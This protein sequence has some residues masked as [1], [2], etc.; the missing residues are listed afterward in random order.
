M[1]W[2]DSGVV[3]DQPANWLSRI[4]RP[5]ASIVIREVPLMPFAKIFDSI[6]GQRLE[7]ESWRWRMWRKPFDL[8]NTSALIELRI[9]N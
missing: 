1:V 8:V 2:H 3:H 6:L 9:H 7:I 5:K 4:G